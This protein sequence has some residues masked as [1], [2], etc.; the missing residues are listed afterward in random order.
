[1]EVWI[2]PG[3]QIGKICQSYALNLSTEFKVFDERN[4]EIFSI[5]GPSSLGGLLGKSQ[6]FQVPKYHIIKKK[7]VFSKFDS[8]QF[9][10][11]L[12]HRYSISI[13][14]QLVISYIN[15]TTKVQITLSSKYQ[16][17]LKIV[18]TKLS[19]LDLHFYL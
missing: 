5:V 3:H 2:S 6:H 12:C 17:V 1:M 9:V 11:I 13:Q 14:P 19:C 4:R 10:S 16:N 18:I 7:N 15:G 8:V